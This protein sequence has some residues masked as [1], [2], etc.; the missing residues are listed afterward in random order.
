MCKLPWL[1]GVSATATRL[2]VVAVLTA[3]LVVA[4]C[5]TTDTS[6]PTTTATAKP[7]PPAKPLRVGINPVMPPFAFKD[8]GKLVGIEPELAQGFATRLKRKLVFVELAWSD[9]IPALKRGDVDMVASGVSITQDRQTVVAFSAPYLNSG[10][11][12]LLPRDRESALGFFFN[13]K[14]KLGVVPGTTGEFFVQAEHARN[15]VK[16]FKDPRE[17]AEAIRKGKIEIMFL[18]APVAWYLAGQYE[19]AGLTATRSLLTNESLA[20][21]TS[22]NNVALLDAATEYLESI[23]RDGFKTQVMRRWLGTAYAPAQ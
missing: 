2:S 16:R 21:A 19:A 14:I 7:E 12:A 1:C 18:D 4:G 10:L 23:R 5:T 6:K 8:G 13:D 20:W 11:V 17:G 22:K 9:L 3:L 15:P